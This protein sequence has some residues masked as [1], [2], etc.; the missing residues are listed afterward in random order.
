MK[1]WF[2]GKWGILMI[3]LFEILV[4]ILLLINPVRFTTGIIFGAGVLLLLGGAYSILRYF[5]VNP[6]LAAQKQLMFR[7]LLCLMAGLV[8]TTQY[9][10]FLTAFPLLTVLYAGWM[11]ILAASKLQLM[12]DQKRKGAARW[13]MPGISALA[14][15]V[16]ASVIL[17]NPFG[18]V[19]AVWTFA[20]IS[21]IAEAALDLAAMMMKAA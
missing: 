6:E 10:W 11:L 21:L 5:L 2:K 17:L 8:C 16:L 18:A 13:Y 3:C 19:N 4:G 15:A 9:E 20:G 12:A 14:A 1:Q 7:G